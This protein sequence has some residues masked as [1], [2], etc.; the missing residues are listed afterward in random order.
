[1]SR[2]QKY[3]IFEWLSW[4][5][6]PTLTNVINIS[7]S[8]DLISECFKVHHKIWFSSC[9]RDA[10]LWQEEI[11]LAWIFMKHNEVFSSQFQINNYFAIGTEWDLF[12]LDLQ[13]KRD[14]YSFSGNI[15]LWET[16]GGPEKGRVLLSFD[17]YGLF[18][19]MT[20]NIERMIQWMQI[21]K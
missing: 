17:S 1:M 8:F 3:T 15:S 16:S 21:W 12:G 7:L 11:S 19:S 6:W 9:L 2:I 4:K 13:I 20:I 5:G 10:I 18:I 14:K